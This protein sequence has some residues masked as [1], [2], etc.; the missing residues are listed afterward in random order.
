M[1]VANRHIADPESPMRAFGGARRDVV[2]EARLPLRN[3]VITLAGRT[4]ESRLIV[5]LELARLAEAVFVEELRRRIA[6]RTTWREVADELGIPRATLWQ[7]YHR[8]LGL[9]PK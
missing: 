6:G 2:E 9:G 8:D 7:N 5:A 1:A 3:V 4:G